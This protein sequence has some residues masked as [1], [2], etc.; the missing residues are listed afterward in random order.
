MKPARHE[1]DNPLDRCARWRWA[2]SVPDEVP[3]IAAA[4][5]GDTVQIRVISGK[6]RY[7]YVDRILLSAWVTRALYEQKPPDQPED[8][9]R[10]M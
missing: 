3:A 9:L 10:N 8:K 6:I 4:Y 5:L 1:P 2:V 7:L